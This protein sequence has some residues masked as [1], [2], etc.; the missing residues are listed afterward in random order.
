[1]SN[2]WDLVNVEEFWNKREY[3]NPER[4]WVTFYCKN[5]EEIVEVERPNPKWYIF[6]CK[7]CNSQDIAIWTLEWIKEK[8]HIK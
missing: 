2:F 1:M 7:K 4:W 3:F 5:C 6:I 8:Y